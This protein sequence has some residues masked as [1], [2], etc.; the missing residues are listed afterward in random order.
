MLIIISDQLVLIQT[1]INVLIFYYVY[2]L[3]QNKCN[4][5]I[6]WRYNFI[7][8]FTLPLIVVNTLLLLDFIRYRTNRIVFNIIVFVFNLI[9]IYCIYTYI[10]D[11]NRINC[12]CAE[13]DNGILHRS[14]YYL[15]YLLILFLL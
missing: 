6:D 1:L 2:N 10:G 4:C 7:K 8:Y 3:E 5:D 15:R 9:N 12:L 11:L 13:K 14:L